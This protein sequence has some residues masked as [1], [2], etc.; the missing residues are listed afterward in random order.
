M[1]INCLSNCSTDYP[2]CDSN[3]RL[4]YLMKLESTAYFKGEFKYPEYEEERQLFFKQPNKDPNPKLK[5][6]SM[7]KSLR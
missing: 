3:C 4:V 6:I 2:F 5:P 7:L 1:C